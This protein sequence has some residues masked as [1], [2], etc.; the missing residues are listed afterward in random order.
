MTGL[1][2]WQ[3]DKCSSPPALVSEGQYFWG[4]GTMTPTKLILAL[5]ACVCIR[6]GFRV[7]GGSIFSA[8]DPY[9][10]D[11]ILAL[12]MYLLLVISCI[13][14]FEL[15]GK[16][17][18]SVLGDK[19]NIAQTFLAVLCG[20]M[21][22][23]FSYGEHALE[24][25]LVSQVDKD[26]VA[27]VWGVY[28]A[29]DRNMVHRFS[30]DAVAFIVVGCGVGPMAEEFFFRGLLLRSLVARL[31]FT[32]AAVLCSIAFTALHFKHQYFLS[33]FV[34]SMF[35]CYLYWHH[36]SLW[37]CGL[38]HAVYNVIAFIVDYYLGSAKI[39]STDPTELITNW[40]SQ[41]LMLAI[42]GVFL[43]LFPIFSN[44]MRS[45]RSR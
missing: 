23:L 36:N 13:S 32:W 24:V 10:M 5:A 41:F 37:C 22:I 45:Q 31:S 33:T 3:L 21:L 1:I 12:G 42:S 43:A 38:A 7:L 27:R 40:T 15:K 39:Y 19:P 35:L 14:S 8:F 28:D 29:A 6:A 16:V 18:G 26:L 34:F 25:F 9:Y 4:K 11:Q 44:R 20:V 30:L 17:L 2:Q